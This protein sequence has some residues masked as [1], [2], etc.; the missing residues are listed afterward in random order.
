MQKYLHL[1]LMILFFIV[2]TSCN[3][4]GKGGAAT[5][6]G[7]IQVKLINKITFDTLTTYD[8]PDERVY[9]V[10]GENE[11]FNDDT[12]TSYNG[13]YKFDYLY[14]GNYTIYAYSECILHLDSCPAE[15]KAVIQNVKIN[16]NK[17]NIDVPTI[18]INKYF[19]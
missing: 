5:I 11:T 16:S 12:K 8:A 17:E 13:N 6:Q 1:F 18:T 9:I 4:E 10:Y 2:I 19:K 7:K 15:I 3:K 14:K